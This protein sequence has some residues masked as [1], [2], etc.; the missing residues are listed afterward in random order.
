[1]S[2]SILE[3]LIGSLVSLFGVLLITFLLIHFVPGD[4]IDLM[5]GEQ[6]SAVDKEA[7]RKSLGLD[8]PFFSQ[9]KNYF[10]GLLQGDLG[11]S[12]FSKRP[13]SQ[14]IIERLPAT[15]ELGAVA[16]IFSFLIGV[17]LGVWAAPRKRKMTRGLSST[18]SLVGLAMPS[19]WLGPILIFIFAVQLEILPVSERGG[20]AN[21]I[22]PVLTLSSGLIALIY[23]MTLASVQEVLGE[24]YVRVALAKGNTPNQVLFKHVLKNA[25]S[26]I[27]TLLGILLGVLLTG[28]VIVETIFD[29]PGLGTLIFE[30]LQ[31]R[32]FPVIQGSVL[33]VA[34]TYILAGI[35]TDILYVLTQPKLRGGS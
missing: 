13:V 2:R 27:L 12:L 1:M 17:P 22:L 16:L 21:L 6:A 23:R 32:D 10:S 11:Y 29:W 33:F 24:D 30:S 18:L 3:R 19:F 9:F 26:P 7:L 4:P 5:L 15:L 25:L 35:I 31:R 8:Q 28:T 20:I 34:S 14:E